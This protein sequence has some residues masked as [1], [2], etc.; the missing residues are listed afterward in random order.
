MWWE[1]WVGEK[2]GEAPGR[3]KKNGRLRSALEAQRVSDSLDSEEGEDAVGMRTLRRTEI[4]EDVE[5]LMYLLVREGIQARAQNV[6]VCPA[7]VVMCPCFFR[8][9]I[10][11]VSFFDVTWGLLDNDSQPVVEYWATE[12]IVMPQRSMHAARSDRHNKHLITSLLP[13]YC[14]RCQWDHSYL[15]KQT[16]VNIEKCFPTERPGNTAFQGF[17]MK[18]T[19]HR[20]RRM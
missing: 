1:G 15:R 11:Y 12:N 17:H 18:G 5:T 13:V 9:T 10:E 7:L 14:P 3:V 8:L 16:P 2:A 6:I 20:L 19:G 4:R